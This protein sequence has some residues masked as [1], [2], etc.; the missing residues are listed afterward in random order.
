M[1]DNTKPLDP[2]SFEITG[3]IIK[4]NGTVMK[5]QN[6]SYVTNEKFALPAFPK[7]AVVLILFGLIVW[8]FNVATG[9]GCLVA[10]CLWIFSWFSER[11]DLKSKILLTL[12]M[13]SGTRIQILFHDKEFLNKVLDVLEEVMKAGSIG[14]KN[15]TVSISNCDISG[16][17]KIL[18]DMGISQDR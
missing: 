14:N 4:W 17:A 7:L 16:N 18:T 3:D 9:L 10:G 6:I 5:I 8:Q 11:E 12:A 15:I 13:N 2:K 1:N